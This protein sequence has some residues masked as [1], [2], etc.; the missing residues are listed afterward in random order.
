MTTGG[1]RGFVSVDMMDAVFVYLGSGGVESV[2]NKKEGRGISQKN[3]ESE[4]QSQNCVA[5]SGLSCAKLKRLPLV[6]AAS[7][8]HIQEKAG[9]MRIGIINNASST[10]YEAM[11][12]HA[13]ALSLEERSDYSK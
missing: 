6:P 8:G 13:A 10:V 9:G 7:L 3:S 1:R 5:M 11:K 12:S 2:R 4:K